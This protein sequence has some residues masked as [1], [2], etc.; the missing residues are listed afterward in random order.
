MSLYLL[1]K[2]KGLSGKEVA[3]E[4]NIHPSYYSHLETGKRKFTPE[5]ITSLAKVL[6]E[7]ENLIRE[8]IRLIGDRASL[9]RSWVLGIKIHGTDV[10]KAFENELEIENPEKFSEGLKKRFAIF[11]GKNIAH[12]VLAEL[13]EDTRLLNTIRSRIKQLE[14]RLKEK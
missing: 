7:P 8:K 11:V 13:Q 12:S 5:L 10:L 1:R 3:R 2:S 14:E 6:N 4:M 9:T